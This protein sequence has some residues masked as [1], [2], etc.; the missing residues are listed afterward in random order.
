MKGSAELIAASSTR[1]PNPRT[2]VSGGFRTFTSPIIRVQELPPLPPC[3]CDDR[4][5][6]SA[7]AQA[8]APKRL[9]ARRKQWRTVAI[10]RGEPRQVRQSASRGGLVILVVLS[11]Q[12]SPGSPPAL[13]SRRGRNARPLF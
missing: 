10:P 9:P 2:A 6:A 8:Q 3:R 1:N 12:R 4:P 11:E 5:S 7:L 13:R